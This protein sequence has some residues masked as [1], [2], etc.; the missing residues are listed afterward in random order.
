MNT[1]NSGKW[2]LHEADEI[3]AVQRVLA[4]GRVN[5]WNG[6][7]GRA[8][9]R[10]FADYCGMPYGLAVANGTLAL[11]LAL[12][13][14]GIGAGDEVVVT[15]RSFIASVACVVNVGAWPVFA[16]V[17]PDSQ[18]IT[19]ESVRAVLSPRTR[20]VLPVHLAGWPCDM[21]GFRELAEQHQ[22]YLIE[23]C[24]QAHGAAWCGQRVGSFGDAATFSFCTDKI[25]S[26]GGEGG[27]LLLH[28]EAAWN[29]AWSRRD[30]GKAWDAVYERDHPP[31]FRWQH[32]SFGTNARM[33]EMQAAI[34]RVQLGKL[35]GWLE[36]RRRNAALLEEILGPVEA[37]HV[38]RPAAHE[39][40]ARY[41]FYFFVRPERLQAGQD[42]DA[43]MS[44]LQAEG[45]PCAQGSCP[46]VY[47]EAAFRDTDMAPAK[48][49][50][51]A[52]QLAETV[53]ALPVHHTLDADEVR[54][55]GERVAT[56]VRAASN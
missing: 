19:P 35:D 33:T 15:P 40:H 48:R 4:S 32:H 11:E 3:E 24:A 26:T 45:V 20:A 17:D 29:R 13:A 43:V 34:G 36:C 16:D 27:M 18:N 56:T 52:R 6:D 46:E 37:L 21:D 49:L 38:S 5:Y 55:M 1:T 39:E 9:E 54:A 51:V 53:L 22:L 25:M 7:E 10:E 2:P 42:R 50:P 44:A 12:N 47:R 28:D 8:F 30:H 14:L 41:R 23:D 31:G